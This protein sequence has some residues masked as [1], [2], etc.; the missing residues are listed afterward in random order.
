MAFLT[1]EVIGGTRGQARVTPAA[2]VSQ[3]GGIRRKR[4]TAG[5]RPFPRPCSLTVP[6][7]WMAWRRDHVPLSARLDVPGV[8]VLRRRDLGDRLAIVLHGRPARGGALPSTLARCCRARQRT[9]RGGTTP[10]GLVV[11]A[12]ESSCQSVGQP[13]SGCPQFVERPGISLLL[14]AGMWP[15]VGPRPDREKG[16]QHAT[17]ERDLLRL[18][19]RRGAHTRPAGQ[20]TAPRCG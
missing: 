7:S 3:I 16:G 17:D 2:K 18:A 15:S 9:S 13:S 5:G 10:Y 11:A 6:S 8:S 20:L 1:I 14:A 12:R 19:S 4:V